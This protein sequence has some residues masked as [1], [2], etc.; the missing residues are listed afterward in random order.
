[1]GKDKF[2]TCK[3]GYKSTTSRIIRGKSYK[4]LTDYTVDKDNS[5][6]VVVDEDNTPSVFLK[7]F[8]D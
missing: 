3:V 1:M 8:F 5:W 2:V 6:Y 7:T 4:V